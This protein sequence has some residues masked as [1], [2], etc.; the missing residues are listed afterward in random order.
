M[1]IRI[2]CEQQDVPREL[3]SRVARAGGFNFFGEPYFRVVWGWSR[4][5]LIGGEWEDYDQNGS[6]LRRAIEFRKE[7]KYFLGLDRF[8][9]EKWMPP[10]TFGT[11]RQWYEMTQEV[12]GGRTIS[13][14]GP[15]PSRGEYEH[16]WTIQTP[17]GEFAPLDV[18]MCETVVRAV[19][20]SRHL[21]RSDRKAAID[22]REER[23]KKDF[24]EEGMALME[25]A[26]PAF[27][28][29]PQVRVPEIG[30]SQ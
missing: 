20:F 8:H 10:E 29:Q 23:K 27:L 12:V 24:E 4:L 17:A 16:C 21:V 19:E 5:T 14:S 18:S 3:Q 11:P 9:M 25:D 2:G 1:Q 30:E 22:R 28:G 13:A 26:R 7:P 6:L 15:Y